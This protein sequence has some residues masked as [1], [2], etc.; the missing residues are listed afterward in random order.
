M[1]KK[2]NEDAP[3]RFDNP[4]DVYEYLKNKAKEGETIILDERANVVHPRKVSR[5]TKQ[6]KGEKE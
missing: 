6:S 5:F 4:K 1:K 2:F 3:K